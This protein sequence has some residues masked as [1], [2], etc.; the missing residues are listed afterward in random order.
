MES[1]YEETVEGM[2]DAFVSV[3]FSWVI[4]HLNSKTAD[5][6]V[7]PNDE[8]KAR[9]LWE[10][11]PMLLDSPLYDFCQRCMESRQ[12]DA[13]EYYSEVVDQWYYVRARPISRGMNIFVSDITNNKKIEE[14][15]TQFLTM[16][17]AIPQLGWMADREGYIH[18]YNDRWYEYTG[19]T[20]EEMEGWG[21]QKVHHPEHV[22][23]VVAYATESWQQDD[24]WELTFPLRGKDGNYR[25]FLTRVFPVKDSA[26]KVQQWI[27]TNTDVHDQ[28]KAEEVLKQSEA[29]LRQ[30]S[31]FMPQLVWT[32]DATGYHD[33]Y[34]E[35][36]YE[37]TG[38]T[39]QETKDTG[40]AK[41]LHPDDVDRTWQIWNHS[42]K[43][44][45]RYETEYRMKRADGEYRWLLARA[46]ALTNEAG[47]TIRWFG[48]CTDIH[49][50]KV[51]N[52]T[53]EQKVAERTHELETAN[54]HLRSVNDELQQFNYVASHDLQEPL[55][56]IKIFSERI[57]LLDFENLSSASQGSL[58]RI[59]DSVDRM[60]NLLKDLLDF[61]SASREDLFTRVNLNEI[62][63][64]IQS[65]LELLIAQK[66]ATLDVADLPTIEAIP[67]QMHQLFYNL[68]NNAVKFAIPDRKPLIRISCMALT[69][70]AIE[71][72][73]LSRKKK[74]FQLTIQ[75]NG[76]GFE[77]QYAEKIF[78]LFKRLHGKQS[79]PG[80]GV[81]L[82]LCKKVVENHLGRIWAESEYG[83]GATF[84]VILPLK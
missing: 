48:T 11:F 38:L 63:V 70:K 1:I 42:L 14:G 62:I 67:L 29:Q 69:G 30:M 43:T 23:R 7:L 57:K 68:I 20:L 64:D 36:W 44:G 41:L 18:W 65:D 2:S 76:I 31:D 3:D 81:G 16:V 39:Y 59:M 45:E 66:S 19:T 5:W 82:A 60:S 32:T 10:A 52:D 13:I 46:T 35:R 49:D 33:F 78:E 58:D 77:P 40:W 6:S 71:Q 37:F 27:G 84:H 51:A 9:S 26:G 4:L 54:E 72:L 25:W 50:Q 73:R 12:S 74:Y 15:Q 8:I 55:R 79:Y 53:L 21:W 22:D 61:S 83:K 56:K 17:N 28:V 47:E 80:T 24:P 75:D 34:N